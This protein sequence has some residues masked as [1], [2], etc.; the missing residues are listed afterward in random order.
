M[1]TILRQL[2]LVHKPQFAF[3]ALLGFYA[4]YILAVTDVS[5]QP[6]G[7]IFKGQS[8]FLDSL[9]F[10]IGPRGCPETSGINH[11]STLPKFPEERISHT[12]V[13]AWK[14]T[15]HLTFPGTIWMLS[16]PLTLRCYWYSGHWSSSHVLSD[17]KSV[18]LR[19]GRYANTTSLRSPN[20]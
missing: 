14:T 9:T 20:S 18:L 1:H 3:F 6:V 5:G 8:V 15:L 17:H 12:K 13:E 11:Q 2:S 19:T 10:Q 4:V 7:Y 16:N